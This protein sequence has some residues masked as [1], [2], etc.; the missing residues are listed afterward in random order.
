M[1]ATCSILDHDSY[2]EFADIFMSQNSESNDSSEHTEDLFSQIEDAFPI[3]DS[4]SV[5]D[6]DFLKKWYVR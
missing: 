2:E 6:D 3:N 4:A 5:Y 1:S